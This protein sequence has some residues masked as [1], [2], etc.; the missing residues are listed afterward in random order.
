MNR[1]PTDLDIS[2]CIATYR[3][4][5][6]LGRLLASL[7]VQ[8]GALPSFEILVVDNDAEGGAL[9]VCRQYEGRL[10]VRYEVE[11]TRG[12]SPARN[13]AVEASRGPYIAFVDDDCVV[14]P[15]W[16]A[17]LYGAAVA[18]GADGVFG[19][20]IMR[21][22][23]EAPERTLRRRNQERR[24]R[25]DGK[26]LAWHMTSACNAC[27]R[28]SALP[29]GAPFD[30]TLALTGGEDVDLFARMIEGGARLVAIKAPV[31]EENRSA[32]RANAAW[33]I[34]RSFRNGGTRAHVE[35]RGV[36]GALLF[37]HG[38]CALWR[39]AS[40]LAHVPF[41]LARSR[42]AAFAW[43][44]ASATALGMAAWTVG[45]VY[46]EYRRPES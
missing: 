14:G 8:A 1:L 17:T 20:I 13:R 23:G 22:E 9:A 45:I 40:C 10:P 19:P 29:S 30:L 21:V 7:A 46:A 5:G 43:L 39:A 38:L 18:S 35:W 26:P 31:I 16:I 12:I 34:R 32:A 11:R 27:I 24:H 25:A 36:R 33:F 37:R 15:D 44:L 6:P 2:I 4:P 28:R 3:R 42:S 41:A